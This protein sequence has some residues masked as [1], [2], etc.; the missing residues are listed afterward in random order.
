MSKT[1]QRMKV[2]ANIQFG[3]IPPLED[4]SA[5]MNVSM[6]NPAKHTAMTELFMG[7]AQYH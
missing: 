2:N 3:L 5:N 1:T 6:V 7:I 4:L